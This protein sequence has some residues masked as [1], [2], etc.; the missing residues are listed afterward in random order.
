MHYRIRGRP[1]ATV[2]GFAVIV[3]YC[4]FTAVS[5]LLYPHEFSPLTH[6]LSRLGDLAYSPVG[7]FFYNAG[8]ILTGIALLPFF[9][10]LY[11]W[12]ASS[13]VQ[14]AILVF[15]QAI[16]LCA[17]FALM[18]IGVFSE[19]QGAPHMLASSV[20]FL[21]NFVVLLFL[22]LALLVHPG[23]SRPIAVFGILLDLSTLWMGIYVGG[24]ITEWYT[25]FGALFYVSLVSV[26]SMRLVGEDAA[27]P[28]ERAT[29]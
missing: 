28:D 26:R 14:R 20:F 10:G 3:L 2:A 16:G 4:T 7:A 24:P 5:W 12:Y 15:G 29:R 13:R 27:H 21:L 11:E 23:F 1:L 18:M 17:A 9:V 25:V 19:D 8:C 6:Y 22:N